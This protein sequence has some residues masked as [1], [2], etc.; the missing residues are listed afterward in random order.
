[1]N[2]QTGIGLGTPW[3]IYARRLEKL[4]SWDSSVSVVYDD[5]AHKVTVHV[6]GAAKAEAIE[7]LLPQSMA[8]GNVI[9]E[10]EVVPAN[11]END[12]NLF[13]A[14]FSGNPA[15]IDVVEGFGPAGDIAYALFA[16]EA[17][18][19]YEDD[20]SEFDGVTTLTIAELASSVLKPNDVRVSSALK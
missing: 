17:V 14:A 2:N 1:M 18:Q 9:L 6:E 12:A 7:K 10:I 11:N 13:R 5:A 20:I 19:L 16:P 8:Y 15:L 4:F 3:A